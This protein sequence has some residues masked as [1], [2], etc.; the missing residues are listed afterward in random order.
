MKLRVLAGQPVSCCYRINMAVIDLEEG[1]LCEYILEEDSF[2]IVVSVSGL[3]GVS[4]WH[5]SKSVINIYT[6]QLAYDFMVIA[7]SMAA[8]DNFPN[9]VLLDQVECRIADIELQISV[10][11]KVLHILEPEMGNNQ[12]RPQL[13][14]SIDEEIFD[15]VDSREINRY[16]SEEC[17]ASVRSRCDASSLRTSSVNGV[18]NHF[19]CCNLHSPLNILQA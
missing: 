4:V 6:T 7:K 17:G 11:S 2:V 16:F 9:E 3:R 5:A 8:V 15:Y 10:P 18:L 1:A 13:F 19:M 14:A 12:R